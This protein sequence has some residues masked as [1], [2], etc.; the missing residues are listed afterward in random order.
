MTHVLVL[1]L[2]GLGLG[3]N[4]PETNPLATASM[5]TISRLLDGG[6]LVIETAPFEGDLASLVA[7]DAQL[8]LSGRP[9]SASGQAV[10]LT[11]RNIPEEIGG[12]YGPKP[13]PVIREI[14]E[15]DNIFLDVVKKGGTAS[16]LNAYPP[17]YFSAIESKRR[18]YSAIPMAVAAANVPLKTFEELQAGAAL[19]V[20]FTG[21]GWNT[22]SGFPYA[23][24]YSPKE[25]G[26]LLANLAR[27]HDLSWFDY[28]LSD[29]AGHRGTR[30]EA[31]E[32]LETLD[33]V[34]EGLLDNWNVQED[35]IILTS[36]HGNVE[37][38]SGRKHTLNPV[39]ALVI[40]PLEQ[41]LAFT[42][43]KNDLTSFYPA[44]LQVIFGE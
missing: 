41:R 1:F 14:L 36:D 13:N 39:P 7:W 21:V 34:L 23:P 30:N 16:L 27:G 37:D 33:E 18:L 4:D 2:D 42:S 26:A 29:Y 8:G 28:W 38:L 24:E 11:G 19:S 5:D 9:Q 10:L 40:G 22:R 43:G 32:L 15:T 20:D 25:A 3:P 17:G 31:V 44:V 35:L 6:S 12:H